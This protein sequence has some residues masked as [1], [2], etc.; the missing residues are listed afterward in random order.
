[1]Q[2]HLENKRERNRLRKILMSHQE[3][4]LTMESNLRKAKSKDNLWN[5]G[6]TIP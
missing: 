3:D 6:K 1:M 2:N 4:Y 5:Y